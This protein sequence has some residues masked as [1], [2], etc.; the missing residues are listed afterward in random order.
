MLS[1]LHTWSLLALL[2]GR[3]LTHHLDSVWVQELVPGLPGTL[4][5]PLLLNL[6]IP[7]SLLTLHVLP[8]LRL[9]LTLHRSLLNGV[10]QL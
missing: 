8:L 7:V 6:L 9:L 10:L 3:C 2:A 5:L 4:L 1:F